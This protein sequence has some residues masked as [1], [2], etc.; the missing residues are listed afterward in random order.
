VSG[1]IFTKL[2]LWL[3][4]TPTVLHLHVLHGLI[5]CRYSPIS[6]L[7]NTIVPK[8]LSR[9][10]LPT[11]IKCLL[12]INEVVVQS[13]VF[14]HRTFLQAVWS[15]KSGPLFF[16]QQLF[17]IFLCTLSLSVLLSAPLY[18][19]RYSQWI[20]APSINVTLIDWS[21]IL[22]RLVRRLLLFC[23]LLPCL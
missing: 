9:P 10:T 6:L 3:Q 16:G 22:R 13:V 17:L 2:L 7:W 23:I 15:L 20:T 14:C 8:H 21:G 4:T 1:C 5:Y 18:Y 19:C 12:E 11:D